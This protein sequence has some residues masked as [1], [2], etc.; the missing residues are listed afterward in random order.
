MHI[1]QFL[2][3]R[4]ASRWARFRADYTW[5]LSAVALVASLVALAKNSGWI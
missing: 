5:A 1:D 3:E 4:K 2:A